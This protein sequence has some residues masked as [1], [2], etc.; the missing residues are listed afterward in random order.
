M[1]PTE[2]E[3]R[4]LDLIKISKRKRAQTFWREWASRHLGRGWFDIRRLLLKPAEINLLILLR[5]D[6]YHCTT[7]VQS[8]VFLGVILVSLKKTF[9]RCSVIYQCHWL[10]DYHSFNAVLAS[11]SL[12]NL[13]LLSWLVDIFQI[14]WVTHK[15][16]TFG[17]CLQ[18][19]EYNI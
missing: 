14:L 4:A 11:N 18:T 12:M 10:I 8:N 17:L 16:A 7:L 2:S 1:Y 6:W 13:S 9:N 15:C 5:G 3:I 19:L